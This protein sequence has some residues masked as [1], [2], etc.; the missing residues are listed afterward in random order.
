MEDGMNNSADSF[1][2]SISAYA[3]L[4]SAL[5]ASLVFPVLAGT[6][7]LPIGETGQQTSASFEDSASLH[8]SGIVTDFEGTP[9][10][11]AAVELKRTDFQS[12]YRCLSDAQGKYHLSVEPG[13][14][15]ALTAIVMED[16]ATK[17]L[18]YWAWNIPA[19]RDLEINPRYDR[20]EVYAMNAWRPQGALPS[21]QVYFRPMTLQRVVNQGG[22]AALKTA[23]LIDVAPDL[24][25]ED[26]VAAIGGQPVAVLEV[27][28]VL[29]A[30]PND[31]SIFAYLIQIALPEKQP[32]TDYWRVSLTITDPATGEMGE[33][34][35]FW[36]KRLYR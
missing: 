6:G 20:I 14:Y 9:I 3:A 33:G 8:I 18:E 34:L 35:L 11:G 30:A 15:I 26:I 36:E 24:T 7:P 4:V 27:N 29:E 17:K 22:V 2:I 28:K 16:Y 12:A 19:F 23:K 10:E 13:S 1:L 21:L 32:D 25:H 5:I 31:Q